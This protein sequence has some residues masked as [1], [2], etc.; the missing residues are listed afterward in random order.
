M[1]IIKSYQRYIVKSK[2]F[3]FI[4]VFLTILLRLA[5]FVYIDDFSIYPYISNSVLGGYIYPYLQNDTWLSFL[6]ATIFA[7][8]ITFYC[9]Y[10]NLKYSLIREKSYLIYPIVFLVLSSHAAFLVMNLHY[11][12]I[13]LFIFCLDILFSSYQLKQIA[14]KAFSIGFVL[15][16]SSFFSFYFLF[17]IILFWIGFVFMSNFSVKAFLSSLLGI[18]SVYW[19]VFFVCLWQN[20]TDAYI[21]L[22]ASVATAFE[23]GYFFKLL[24][25]N[26]CIVL[27]I[28]MIF[29]FIVI[30]YN[31]IYSYKD[32]IRVR[33]MIYFLDVLAV[34][35][36][37]SCS[38]INLDPVV[39]LYIYAISYSFLLAHFFS[40]AETKLQ[41]TL[42]YIF[43]ASVLIGAVLIS[44]N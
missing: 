16:I 17:Y 11:V 7:L 23:F 22:F 27:G 38:F 13:L 25:V 8:A 5:L 21:S 28:N 35:T 6:L 40:V 19:L 14:D 20:N 2:N 41:V 29:L 44:Q 37:L 1:D 10:I 36:I 18:V 26:E 42:F 31:Q 15:A 9:A 39:D 34:S 30:I 32:K 4:A 24:S 3:I 43:L 33:N 12:A